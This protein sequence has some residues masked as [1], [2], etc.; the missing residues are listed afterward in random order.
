MGN[1]ARDSIRTDMEFQTRQMA[2]EY[3]CQGEIEL[4]TLVVSRQLP[5]KKWRGGEIISPPRTESS[6]PKFEMIDGTVD[7]FLFLF[8]RKIFARVA[9]FRPPPLFRFGNGFSSPRQITVFKVFFLLYKVGWSKYF[10]KCHFRNV[11]FHNQMS[12]CGLF[13]RFNTNSGSPFQ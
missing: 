9:I 3:K 13:N 6:I 10:L 12:S 1:N 7:T 5:R 11:P 8:E 2:V 4:Q